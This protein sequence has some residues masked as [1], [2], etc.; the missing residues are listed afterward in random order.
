MSKP[1][2]WLKLLSMLED[3]DIRKLIVV[4][5]GDWESGEYGLQFKTG[6]SRKASQKRCHF[7]QRLTAGEGERHL[8]M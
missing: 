8:D 4:T 7:E 3:S 6:W 5:K 1:N 2:K